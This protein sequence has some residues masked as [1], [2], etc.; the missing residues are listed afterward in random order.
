[1][2]FIFNVLYNIIVNN[3][4]YYVIELKRIC[5]DNLKILQLSFFHKLNCA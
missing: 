1:M 4:Y 2:K 3:I 5:K